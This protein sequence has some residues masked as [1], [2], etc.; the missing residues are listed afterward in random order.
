MHSSTVNRANTCQ[1]YESTPAGAE[2]RLEALVQEHGLVLS[3]CCDD[4]N[5][6]ENAHRQGA[7]YIYPRVFTRSCNQFLSCCQNAVVLEYTPHHE[8]LRPLRYKMFV[9]Y[10]LQTAPGFHSFRDILSL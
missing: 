8:A 1:R 2:A 7:N 3:L 10:W 5:D 4:F 6:Q 9:R